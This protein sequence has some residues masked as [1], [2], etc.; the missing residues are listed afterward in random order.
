MDYTFHIKVDNKPHLLVDFSNLLLSFG[1][2]ASLLRP[3]APLL[4]RLFGIHLLN[5]IYNEVRLRLIHPE[6]DPAF[7]MKTLQV[8]GTCLEM[9]RTFAENIP[10]EGP[11]IVVVNHPYGGVDGVALGA[12]L[13]ESRSDAKLMGNYLLSRIDG[14]WG[15]II[16]VDPFEKKAFVCANLNGMREAKRWLQGGGCLGVF[17]AGEVSA[18]NWRNFSVV[19]RAWSSHIASLALSSGATVL[20]IYFE[21]HNRWFFQ[22]AGFLHPR[23][24]TLLLP[25][26]FCSMRNSILRVRI[27]CPIYA[28]VLKLMEDRGVVSDYLRLQTYLLKKFHA[29]IK[30]TS[31]VN[32]PFRFVHSER[33]SYPIAPHQLRH[34]LRREIASLPRSACMLEH[35]SFQVFCAKALMIP[36]CLKEIGRLREESFR[37]VGEGTGDAIDLDPFDEYYQHLFI[38]DSHDENIVGAY[39]I[40]LV[41][42]IIEEHGKEGLY[43]ASLFKFRQ[44]F[45]KKMGPA[46]ELGRSFITLNYQKKHASLSLLWKGIGEFIVR[47]LKYKTLFGPVSIANSYATLSKDL[48][49]HYLREHNFDEELSPFVQ[50]RRPPRSKK[51]MRGISIK[52]IGKALDSLGAVSAIVSSIEKDKK[53]IPVLLRH[54]LKLNGSLLSFNVDRAFSDVVDGL[55]LVDLLKTDSKILARYMGKEG[56]YSFLQYH[57][58]LFSRIAQ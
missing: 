32:L 25:R 50:A 42:K 34:C 46:L 33:P 26:E 37:L 19:D 38:W 11:L 35:G 30:T 9:D 18:F 55:I 40:G 2:H 39:R 23:L 6:H 58:T 16:Q 22:L 41:D 3:V 13:S 36:I 21:G 49:V 56:Y 17:P 44:D 8:M 1:K 27:G 15:S 5:R 20:P 29:K 4:E 51:T 43:T 7:F 48:M 12:L 45:L 52:S 47:N 31:R 14:I 24:R 10:E 57:T 53:G 54:Y 28:D